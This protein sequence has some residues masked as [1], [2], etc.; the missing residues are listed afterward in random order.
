[1]RCGHFGLKLYS[2]LLKYALPLDIVICKP[3]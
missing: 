2:A 1:M 3:A